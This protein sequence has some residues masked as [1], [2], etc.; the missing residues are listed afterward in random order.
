MPSGSRR[1][2]V[3]DVLLALEA[4][5]LLGFFR[6]ALRLV[7]VRRILRGMTRQAS[8]GGE[9]D[10]DDRTIA[11]AVR[12]RWAVLAVTRHSPARF[13][14]FPQS[15]ATYVMLRRRGVAS[16]IVY[17]VARSPEGELLAHTWV[18]IGDR[19]VIG[20]EGSGGFTP[21]DRWT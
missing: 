5:A 10:P 12:V 17:G 3:G 15:L 16:T 20:G 18:T 6:V 19:I 14:C 21:I 13:V 9:H 7:S 4:L 8:D 11:E 1:R 2:T